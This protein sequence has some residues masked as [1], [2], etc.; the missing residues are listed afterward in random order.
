[1]FEKTDRSLNDFGRFLL[2]NQYLI[3]TNIIYNCMKKILS[4]VFVMLVFAFSNQAAE[5]YLVKKGKTNFRIVLSDLPCAIEE[6]A[7]KELKMYL[8]ESTKINW[9][10][11]S[12]KD[13]PEDVPQILI[14]NSSRAKKFFPEVFQNQIPYDGIEIHL[15]GNMLLLAGHEQRGVIYAVNTFL[16]TVLGIRWWTSTEQFVTIH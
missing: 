8:D 7:A 15:K 11:T 6:T 16:E 12:E 1:M 3:Y 9:E 14:G 13:I 5:R 10:I 4:L 2:L